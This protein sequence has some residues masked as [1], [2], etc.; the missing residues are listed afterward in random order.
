[1]EKKNKNKN[2]DSLIEKEHLQQIFDSKLNEIEK[3]EIRIYIDTNI[4][5][6]VYRFCPH[7]FFKLVEGYQNEFFSNK[8]RKIIRRKYKKSKFDIIENKYIDLYGEFFYKSMYFMYYFKSKLNKNYF[9]ND[10]E[11]LY[12]QYKYGYDLHVKNRNKFMDKMF[13]YLMGTTI[14]AVLLFLNDTLRKF[15]VKSEFLIIT[16]IIFAGLVLILISKNFENGAYNK[17]IFHKFLDDEFS[18]K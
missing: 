15:E 16:P 7:E 4:G 5:L 14:T 8:R 3:E 17:E 18:N 11:K 9:D 1:M 12:H 13:P 6:L 2:C 10:A